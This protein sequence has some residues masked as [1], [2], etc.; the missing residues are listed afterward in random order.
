MTDVIYDNYSKITL[1]KLKTTHDN[2]PF[3]HNFDINGEIIYVKKYDEDS[4]IMSMFRGFLAWEPADIFF[5]SIY[6]KNKI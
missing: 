2:N 1:E 4:S 6:S 3:F 5:K